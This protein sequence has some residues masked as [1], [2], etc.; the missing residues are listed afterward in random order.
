MAALVLTLPLSHGSS[1]SWRQH[2]LPR[3]TMAC[4]SWLRATP[5]TPAPCIWNDRLT[6]KG[7]S[8]CKFSVSRRMPYADMAPYRQLLPLDL[9]TR[10]MR[11]D[12]DRGVDLLADDSRRAGEPDGARAGAPGRRGAIPVLSA[13]E[14]T[15]LHGGWLQTR[16]N[17]ELFSHGGNRDLG[18]SVM[19][20][21]IDRWETRAT[22]VSRRSLKFHG[23]HRLQLLVDALPDAR[24]GSG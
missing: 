15:M 12:I 16:L 2:P 20:V 4:R 22:R 14:G 19:P 13:L 8:A 7:R 1:A 5:A 9:P 24:A 18:D 17:D 11:R 3:A 10:A 23:E 21:I 6:P